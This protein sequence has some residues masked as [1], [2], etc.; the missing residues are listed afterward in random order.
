M[1]AIVDSGNNLPS[2]AM[3]EEAEKVL[4][5][6]GI[7]KSPL[8]ET[9]I[10][11]RSANSTAITVLGVIHGNWKLYIGEVTMQVAEFIVIK[12]LC[13]PIN[14]G[15]HTLAQLN[16]SINFSQNTLEID[17]TKVSMSTPNNSQARIQRMAIGTPNSPHSN[18]HN[19]IRVYNETT[20]TIPP[21]SLAFIRVTPNKTET[22]IGNIANGGIN[23]TADDEFIENHGIETA[24]DIITNPNELI[25]PIL[26]R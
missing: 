10:I 9:D 5:R 4:R 7:V 25:L 16:A 3:S 22:R 17:G 14:I 21:N 13:H 18:I 26:N 12:N 1:Q 19:E 15:Y 8:E 23:I 24:L 11:A 6:I 20:R 2:I